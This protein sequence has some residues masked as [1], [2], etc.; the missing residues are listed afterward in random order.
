MARLPR[1]VLPGH[2]HLVVQRALPARPAFV[3]A[4]DRQ[5]YLDVLHRALAGEQV[6]L[7]AYALGSTELL[8]LLTPPGPHQIARVM[9]AIG[10]EYV[11]AYNRRQGGVGSLWAGRFRCAVLE[12]GEATMQAM[13]LVDLVSGEAGVTSAT[14]HTGA[15]RRAVLV[16]PPEY[17]A[18]GNTPFERESAYRARL[19]AGLPPGK[20]AELRAAALGG[21]AVGS[22]AFLAALAGDGRRRPAPRTRGRPRL[23]AP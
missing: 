23:T 6:Q 5:A 2:P 7:H 17:W 10:R 3:D 4:S 22:P 21:W 18:L 16:D 12:P 9:Q 11:S 19:A 1:L 15:D 20:A 14:H 8:L 13:L